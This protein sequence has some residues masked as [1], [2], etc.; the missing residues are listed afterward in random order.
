MKQEFDLPEMSAKWNCKFVST[1]V[2]DVN[3]EA[4]HRTDSFSEHDQVHIHFTDDP[5]I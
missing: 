2:V 3:L 5:L 4:T 1:Q